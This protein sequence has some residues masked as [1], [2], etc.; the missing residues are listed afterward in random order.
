MYWLNCNLFDYE[1]R[2]KNLYFEIET[3]TSKSQLLH[4]FKSTQIFY[5]NFDE[6]SAYL[7]I[8]LWNCVLYS[9]DLCVMYQK[10]CV[11]F[12]FNSKSCINAIKKSHKI[13]AT[14][15]FCVEVK[16]YNT[17]IVQWYLNRFNLFVEDFY[18]QLF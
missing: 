5:I 10:K 11:F 6:T 12:S 17:K 7:N 4:R 15:N 2:Q 8:Y 13:N 14:L 1:I 9:F 3:D 18:F 16:L